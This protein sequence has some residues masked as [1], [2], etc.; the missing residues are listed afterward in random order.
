MLQKLSE[1]I[2]ACHERAAEARDKAEATAD[3][4]PRA[5]FLDMETRWLF[6]ARSYQFT[7]GLT[8]FTAANRQRQSI[9]ER[10]RL[11]VSEDRVRKVL[12]RRLFD[13]LP[14]A[15]YVC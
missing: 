3:P 13:D 10:Q 12:Q 2:R 14:V 4:T 5:D 11:G 9:S 7:E 6:L 8:D 15:V 1:Q